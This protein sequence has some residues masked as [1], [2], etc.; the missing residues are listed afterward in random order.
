[1]TLWERSH[2]AS[3]VMD[4]QAELL[5]EIET[6]LRSRGISATK[7]G[8]LSVNDGKF[9]PRL[10][11][12]ANMNVATIRRVRAFLMESADAIPPPPDESSPPDR[13]SAA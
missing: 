10:R 4:I 8:V 3:L 7:F 2:Y 12:G 13:A 5:A 1:M 9:V 11:S 6:F